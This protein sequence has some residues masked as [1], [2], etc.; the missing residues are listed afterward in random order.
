MSATRLTGSPARRGTFSVPSASM[1][2]VVHHVIWITEATAFCDCHGF[3]HRQECRHVQQVALAVE[4][5]ARDLVS[6]STP[7][8]RAEAAARLARIEEEFAR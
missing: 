3:S 4:I 7:E 5:E 6:N 2:G 8:Q 1:P